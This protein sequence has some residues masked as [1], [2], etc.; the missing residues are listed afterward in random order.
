M[1]PTTLQT[2]TGDQALLALPGAQETIVDPAD[3]RVLAGV[4]AAAVATDL[5]VRS[6]VAGLTGALLVAVAA[7]ALLA[8]G[9]LHTPSARLATAAAP[10]F[11]VWLAI[12]ASPWLV[13]L[14]VLAA[15]GLLALGA[16]L[17]RGGSLA[18]LTIPRVVLR[19]IHAGVHAVAAPAFVAAPVRAVRAQLGGGRRAELGVRIARGL[20]LAAP[21]VVLLGV[22]LASADAVFA[23][24]FRVD[25]DPV[26]PVEH[27]AALAAGAWGA[28]ALLRVASVTPPGRLP[29][30]RPPIGAVEACIVL[31]GLCA[32][33]AVFTAA[34]LVALSEGGRHVLATAGLTYAEYARSG[35]FQLLAVAVITL[36]ILLLLRAAT[37]LASP[38]QRAV[39]TI[40]AEVAVALTL[41]V[42]VVAV[43]RLNL[44]E[45]AF[46]L[47]MLRLYSELF[48]YWI[49]AVFL[50]LGAAL[51]GVGHGRGWFVGAAVAAGLALLLALNVVNPEAVVAGDQLAG[52]RQVRRTDVGYVARL[53]EDAIPTVAA[54]LP[55]LDPVARADLRARLC[56]AEPDGVPP[57]R[58]TGWAAWNLGRERAARAVTRACG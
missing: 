21:I 26:T 24:F 9:R 49:G 45:D 17:A 12:R 5:A 2:R 18:D 8:S 37:G 33:F 32:L 38:G 29:V 28:A 57:S 40:V 10:V 35:F 54:R 52:A 36:G 27:V 31:A 13:P 56:A 55:G 25:V 44:Y 6:G 34:Q 43:R 47:T 16:S 7:A 11:G 14:D 39:F 15:G 41:V 50:F 42:V 4:V 51:A 19:A 53:S 22:L 20:L 30:L 1:Q 58:F 3:G 48:S 23:S 46:G